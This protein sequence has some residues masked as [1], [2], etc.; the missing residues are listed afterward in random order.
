MNNRLLCDLLAL[1]LND[2]LK[3]DG[4]IIDFNGIVRKIFNGIIIIAN[5]ININIEDIIALDVVMEIKHE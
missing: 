4:A 5:G 1:K 2:D 3:S